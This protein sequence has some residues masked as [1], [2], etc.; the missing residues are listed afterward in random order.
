VKIKQKTCRIVIAL[1]PAAKKEPAANA[2][3]IT[4]PCGNYRPAFSLMMLKK[5]M[6]DHIN[7]L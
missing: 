6:I 1:I 2:C 5:P 7:I 3:I 4:V